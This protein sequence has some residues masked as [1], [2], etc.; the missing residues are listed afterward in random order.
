MTDEIYEGMSLNAVAFGPVLVRRLYTHPD[1][2]ETCVD[3]LQLS[4]ERGET[5]H[6]S[7][8]YARRLLEQ[9]K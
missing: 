6:V 8:A 2:G 1:T 5:L 4:S 9:A 3:C 7:Q